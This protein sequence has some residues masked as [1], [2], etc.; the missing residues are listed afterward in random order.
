MLAPRPLFD[1]FLSFFFPDRCAGCAAAGAI[2]CPR[3]RTGL[4]PYPPD[5][6]VAVPG[7]AAVRI[8][9]LYDGALPPAIRRFK[10]GRERRMADL[11]GGLLVTDAGG[12]PRGAQAVLPV[13]LHAARQAERGFNQAEELARR[14]AAAVRLPLLAGGL[15]RVR[16]TQQ[17]ARL[18]AHERRENMRGAF[19]WR[20]TAPPP[21]RVLIVDDVL[22]TGATMGACAE[23]LL[24]A[25]A[26]QVYGLA[27]ARSRPD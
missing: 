23:A 26:Q 3:C 19:V 17:Q 27:L 12:V 21:A 24:A 2:L 7:L 20:G 22:T 18:G 8:A 11:L 6:R 9:Y 1:A 16:E 4:T 15:V 25:G 10:Y 14:V 5:D 13:P